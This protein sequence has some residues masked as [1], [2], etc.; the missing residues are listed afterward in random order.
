MFKKGDRHIC[1]NY[2][3]VCEC[4]ASGIDKV[5]GEHRGKLSLT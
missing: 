3:T 4:Y 1:N 2:N 5:L